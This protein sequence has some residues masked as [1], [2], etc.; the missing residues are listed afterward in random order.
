MPQGCTA[1][2]Q[3]AVLQAAGNQ[4]SLVWANEGQ[5][6]EHLWKCHCREGPTLGLHRAGNALAN[7]ARMGEG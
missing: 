3:Q 5:L 1:S 7:T 2:G 6:K 4:R